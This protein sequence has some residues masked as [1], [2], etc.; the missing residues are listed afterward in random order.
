M[1]GNQ[2]TAGGEY[3][4]AS[5]TW[6]WSLHSCLESS[7]AD[8]LSQSS[9]SALAVSDS[10]GDNVGALES[11]RFRGER[12]PEVEPCLRFKSVSE[13][14]KVHLIQKVSTMNT[15][16]LLQEQHTPC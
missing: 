15:G 10:S 7:S 11:C 2:L 16:S 6:S 5:S 14:E 3:A 9:T 1:H 12:T 8:R 13:I 4:V